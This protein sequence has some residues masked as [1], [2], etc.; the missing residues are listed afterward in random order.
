MSSSHS[1]KKIQPHTASNLIML[2][3]TVE[4][5]NLIYGMKSSLLLFDDLWHG[6]DIY[7]SAAAVGPYIL[8]LVM[9]LIRNVFQPNSNKLL[10]FN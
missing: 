6:N 2:E 9:L 1:V 5:I 8:I 7:K 4:Y 10:L 3:D